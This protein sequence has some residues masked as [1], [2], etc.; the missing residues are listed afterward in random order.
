[1]FVD[2]VGVADLPEREKKINYVIN[3]TNIM[4][5]WSGN[6]LVPKVVGCQFHAAGRYLAKRAW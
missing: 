1:M 4:A 2:C 6:D 5:V 3:F